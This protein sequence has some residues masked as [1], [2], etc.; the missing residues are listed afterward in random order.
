MV[1][2][3]LTLSICWSTSSDCTL[4]TGVCGETA[5]DLANVVFVLY[6]G[7]SGP[8][9]DVLLTF[10]TNSAAKEFP[11]QWTEQHGKNRLKLQVHKL[12]FMQM[13]YDNVLHISTQL[14]GTY[15]EQH[16]YTG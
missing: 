1:S 2:W 5:I 7:G 4:E 15:M 16:Y 9:K 6:Q 10:D 3:T 12:M 13:L 14:P 11:N 8:T